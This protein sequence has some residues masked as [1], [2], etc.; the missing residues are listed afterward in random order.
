[1]DPNPQN[2]PY[3][4]KKRTAIFTLLYLRHT[5]SGSTVACNAP[6]TLAL[7]EKQARIKFAIRRKSIKSPGWA[8]AISMLLSNLFNSSRNSRMQRNRLA[9]FDL[10]GVA[11]MDGEKCVL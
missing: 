11:E 6:H 4:R 9:R 5:H 2:V 1:V 8:V 7:P 3:R 10:V